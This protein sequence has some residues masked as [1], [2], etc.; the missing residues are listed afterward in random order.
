MEDISRKGLNKPTNRTLQTLL[1]GKGISPSYQRLRVLRYLHDHNNH[2]SVDTIYKSLS[3][4]IPTLSKTTVYNTLKLFVDRGV[5]SSLTIC[6]NEA[7]YDA[8]KTPHA[9]FRCRV[10]G[11]IY[12]VYD[13]KME[14]PSLLDAVVDGHRIEE[15]QL[16]LSG[17]CRSCKK[18]HGAVS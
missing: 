2:P 8:I 16:N 6:D 12:D 5:V 7:R 9:H 3:G 13:L 1:K 17:E 15:A 4:D 14:S 11:R 18:K 10:C